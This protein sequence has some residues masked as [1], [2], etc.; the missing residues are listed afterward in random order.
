[1][2]PLLA[3]LAANRANL[4][5]VARY[6]DELRIGTL[7]R[8]QWTVEVYIVIGKG[9]LPH[10]L[11][12]ELLETLSERLGEALAVVGAVIHQNGTAFQLE[13]VG[14]KL[15][16]DVALEGVDEADPEDVVPDLGDVYVGG[17]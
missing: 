17:G 12:A 14:G 16:H 15:R 10:D 13:V 5:V 1:L 4:A 9:S 7:Q 2:D 3:R 11:P 8:T 6:E